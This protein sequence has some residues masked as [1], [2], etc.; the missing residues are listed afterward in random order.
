MLWISEA[1]VVNFILT[2]E[3]RFLHVH[4]A[5]LFVSEASRLQLRLPL[6]LRTNQ[7]IKQVNRNN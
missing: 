6:A 7:T 2:Y 1:Q 4:N 5:F 3:G